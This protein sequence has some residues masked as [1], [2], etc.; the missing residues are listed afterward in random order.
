M[1][2]AVGYARTGQALPVGQEH[3]I[4]S[5]A[6]SAGLRLIG[7]EFDSGGRHTKRSRALA[8]IRGGDAQVLIVASLPA[9]APSSSEFAALVPRIHDGGGRFV[10][11]DVDLDT[12]LPSSQGLVAALRKL[13]Q[14]DAASTRRKRS[15]G[16]A[17]GR[18]P[19]KDAVRQRILRRYDNGHSLSRI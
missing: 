10:A 18:A 1:E 13:T 7:I 12:G 5:Y 11:L 8:R 19:M 6:D 4:R 3:D 16:R 14:L 9:F 2:G 15:T 17:R